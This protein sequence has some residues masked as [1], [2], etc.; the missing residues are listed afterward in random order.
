MVIC[1]YEDCKKRAHF[2]FVHKNPTRCTA[3]KTEDMFNVTYK[4]CMASDC[5]ILPTQGFVSNQPSHCVIHCSDN[6]IDV[7]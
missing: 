6:M 3:H 2:G 5:H 1:N 4:K 7:T